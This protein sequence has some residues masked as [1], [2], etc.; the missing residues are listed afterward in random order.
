MSRKRRKPSVPQTLPEQGTGPRD[1]AREEP[2]TEPQVEGWIF[3]LP[4]ERSSPAQSSSNDEPP[5]DALV[6]RA[7]QSRGRPVPTTPETPPPV[8]AAPEPVSPAPITQPPVVEPTPVVELAETHEASAPSDAD[9]GWVYQA[10]EGESWAPKIPVQVVPAHEMPDIEVGT[11]SAEEPEEEPA[12]EGW[13][14]TELPAAEESKSETGWI[15]AEPPTRPL[16][17]A[18]DPD[19]DEDPFPVVKRPK[20]GKR[21]REPR[22]EERARLRWIQVAL[23]AVLLALCAVLPFAVPQ[24]ASLFGDGTKQPVVITDPPVSPLTQVPQT[25]VTPTTLVG[26]RL[27]AAGV[28]LEVRVPRLHVDS[29]VIPISGQTGELLPPSDPQQL[30][31]WQEGRQAGAAHGSVV[32]TGHTVSTGGGAFDHLGELVPGDRIRVRTG[33]GWISYEVVQSHNITVAQLAATAHEIFRTD[34]PGRLVLI[35]CSNFNG[36]VYLTNSVV[37]AVPVKDS[38]FV[39][40]SV[41]SFVNGA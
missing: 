18:P 11:S 26:Q 38:P 41:R 25:S 32:V 6:A 16:K 19:E 22:P 10:S 24:I 14:F 27:G 37:Y 1:L 36:V 33:S 20:V 39:P 17:V 4:P 15:F 23:V 12:A 2:D 30:G 28:P 35:T 9:A 31:W 7:L 21:K 34:G 3:D 40:T 8:V 13:V 5:I 29:N